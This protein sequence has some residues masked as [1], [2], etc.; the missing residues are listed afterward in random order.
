LVEG[1]TDA[2]SVRGAWIEG[3]GTVTPPG[4]L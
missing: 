2:P 3:R 4:S 1:D